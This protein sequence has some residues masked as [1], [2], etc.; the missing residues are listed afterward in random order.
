[1]HI[2]DLGGNILMTTPNYQDYSIPD[3]IENP[4]NP[5]LTST[6]FIDPYNHL[7]KNNFNTG[8]YN[9]LCNVHRKK[10]FSGLQPDF[11]IHEISPSRTFCTL[12]TSTLFLASFT[13]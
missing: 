3:Q 13:C 11:K 8:T 6:L 2:M 5:E 4:N 7:T 12:P 9:V 10:I 1:M